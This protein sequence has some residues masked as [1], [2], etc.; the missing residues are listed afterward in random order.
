MAGRRGTPLAVHGWVYGLEDGLLRDL[1]VTIEA[2]GALA[3]AYRRAIERVAPASRP[4]QSAS[5]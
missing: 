3:A 1:A 2:P 4:A 5:R